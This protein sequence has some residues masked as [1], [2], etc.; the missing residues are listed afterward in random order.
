MIVN[1]KLLFEIVTVVIEKRNVL[2][3]ILPYIYVKFFFKSVGSSRKVFEYIDRVP[4][5]DITSKFIPNELKGKIEFQNIHFSYP[6]QPNN[7]ILC[8]NFF[9][10]KIV[11]F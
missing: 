3:K 8:V 1:L 7:P 9:F 4:K 2:L 10:K 6:T 11:L 5:I